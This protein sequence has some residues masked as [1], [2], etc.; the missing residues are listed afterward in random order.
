[1]STSA[2]K[3]CATSTLRIEYAEY[4]DL[5]GEP[6]ILLHGFPDAPVAWRGVV[7]GLRNNKGLRI[8]VPCL[9]GYGET[10]VLQK[11][12]IGGQEAA[13]GADLLEFADALE[14]KTFHVAGHDWGARTAY[15][16]CVFAPD[17]I[18]SLLAL[19]TPYVLYGGRDHPPDEV[20]AHWYQWFFQ[21]ELGR[22]MMEENAE[23]F[24]LELWRSWSPEWQFS[25]REFAE[26]AKA[27]RNPQFVATVLHYYRTRWGGA[28]TLRAYE[29]LQAT[30]NE[31]PKAKINVPTIYVQGSADASDLPASSK[32]QAAYFTVG[33]RRVILKGVGHFPHREK[34]EVIAGLLQELINC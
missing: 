28:L 16:A 13:L 5:H 22:K 29:R 10:E 33:Y 27:W 6:L 8:L 7:Y 4:G 1:M 11:D 24:C 21:L 20:R 2:S 32:E 14:L 9:R 19:A 18:K 26:A 17:R 23:A 25:K 15:A 12:L 3:F 30:L 31:K 34:P